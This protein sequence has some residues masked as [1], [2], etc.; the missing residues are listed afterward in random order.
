MSKGLG[1]FNLRVDIKFVVLY[2]VH[3]EVASPDDLVSPKD[4]FGRKIYIHF[5]SKQTFF[6]TLIIHF[7][8]AG[9]VE[10]SL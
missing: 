10:F 3:I 6:F 4:Q 5:V 9:K 2:F 8:N 1:L 7:V